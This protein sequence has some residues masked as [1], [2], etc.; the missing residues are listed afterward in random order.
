MTL[1]FV[2]GHFTLIVEI[3]ISDYNHYCERK[4]MCDVA[5]GSERDNQKCADKILTCRKYLMDSSVA[6][7]PI[8]DAV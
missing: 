5:R 6:K 4:N 7:L 8:Q 1:N 2:R 3:I